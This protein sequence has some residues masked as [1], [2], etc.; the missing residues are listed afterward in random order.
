MI[1]KNV[2]LSVFYFS[3]IFGN[4]RC[5]V[6]KCLSFALKFVCVNEHEYSTQNS[7]YWVNGKLKKK[8]DTL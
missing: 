2:V 4:M 7:I 3:Y 6:L 8:R 1:L 5:N